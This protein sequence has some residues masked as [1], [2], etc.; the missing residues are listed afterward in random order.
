[1]N[2]PALCSIRAVR[3]DKWKYI[4]NPCSEDELYDME[5]DPGELHNLAPM[6][7]FKH[8]L[9]RMKLLMVEWLQATNDS[10]VEEDSWK[11]CPYDLYITKREQ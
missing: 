11:G 4:Y 8:V 1:M 3:T 2:P 9:R 5:T 10:I 6:R 7:G